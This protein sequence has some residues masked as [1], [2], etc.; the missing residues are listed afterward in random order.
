VPK[1]SAAEIAMRIDGKPAYLRPPEGLGAAEMAL[2]LDVV[3]SCRPEHFQ[4][5]DLPLLEQY[6]RATVAERGAFRRI[7]ELGPATD[8]AKPWLAAWR[9]WHKAT[10]NLSL[11]LRLSPQGRKQHPPKVIDQSPLSVYERMAMG[12]EANDFDAS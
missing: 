11:R 8:E 6:I 3:G 4:S 10:V 5:S 7:H 1:R 12:G 2:F 9:D